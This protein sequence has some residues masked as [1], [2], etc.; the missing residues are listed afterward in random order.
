MLTSIGPFCHSYEPS[1]PGK[2]TCWRACTGQHVSLPGYVATATHDE[3]ASGRRMKRR[4][5]EP[6][7]DEPV[8]GRRM[9]RWREE[10]SY[11]ES[12]SGRRMKEERL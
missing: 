10:P 12:V 9:K 1:H 8:S 2:E 4:R 6:S 11:D 7:E 3:A 5:E